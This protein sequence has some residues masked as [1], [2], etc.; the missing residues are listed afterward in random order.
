MT[1]NIDIRTVDDLT[2]QKQVNN[3]HL[4]DISIELKEK[5]LNK[6]LDQKCNIDSKEELNQ[7]EVWSNKIEYMLSVIG[8]VVDLGSMDLSLKKN[9]NKFFFI[10]L[11]F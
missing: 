7:R 4:N 2:D 9:E 10:I 1:T 11:N 8:Y 5:L 6:N 3:K